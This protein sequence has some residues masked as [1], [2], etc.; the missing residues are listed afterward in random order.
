MIH[1]RF[2]IPT[3][4]RVI[5][6]PWDR[7]SARDERDDTPPSWQQAPPRFD[8]TTALTSSGRRMKG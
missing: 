3:D 1:P 5:R 4:I 2:T 6:A 7:L 8:M